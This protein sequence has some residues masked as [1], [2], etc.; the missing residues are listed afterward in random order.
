MYS[1]CL[2]VL[3]SLAGYDVER[4]QRKWAVGCGTYVFGP[5]VER[6]GTVRSIWR[7]LEAS[8]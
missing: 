6:F 7:N 2:L 3:N 1:S 8:I 5:E 4:T